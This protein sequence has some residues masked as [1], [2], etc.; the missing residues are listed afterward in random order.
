MSRMRAGKPEFLAS[1]YDWGTEIRC[2]LRD[3]DRIA[4]SALAQSTQRDLVLIVSASLYHDIVETGFYGLDATRFS[5]LV[6]AGAVVR[7]RPVVRLAPG[8]ASRFPGRWAVVPALSGTT[9][10][11]P[12][13]SRGPG[14]TDPGG[15]HIGG[16]DATGEAPAA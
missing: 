5:A 10:H 7:Q 4:R 3:S 12:A 11:R 14:R 6:R 16:D 9:A 15:P 8:C 2:F 1:P 13:S